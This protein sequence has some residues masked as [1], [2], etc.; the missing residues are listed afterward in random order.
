GIK[1]DLE[2]WEKYA[3]GG[4]GI[5]LGLASSRSCASN[6]FEVC[7]LLRS[8]LPSNPSPLLRART[9]NVR[10]EDRVTAHGIFKVRRDT[11]ASPASKKIRSPLGMQQ[12]F[13]EGSKLLRSNAAKKI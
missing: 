4:R 7:H 1:D 13:G 3:D 10:R 2:Q 9:V 8:S 12:R 6:T 11:T 5:A